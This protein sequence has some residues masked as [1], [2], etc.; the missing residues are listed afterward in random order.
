MPAPDHTS[1]HLEHVRETLLATIHQMKQ[2]LDA[3]LQ[4]TIVETRVSSDIHRDMA[5]ASLRAITRIKSSGNMHLS[6][7]DTIGGIGENVRTM[8]LDLVEQARIHRLELIS[9]LTSAITELAHVLAE[10]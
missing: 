2:Q 10:T 1:P 5:Q 7:P 4:D 8:H 9:T 3:A 6:L